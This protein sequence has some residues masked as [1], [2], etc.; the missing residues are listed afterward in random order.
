MNIAKDKFGAKFRFN[1]NVRKIRTTSDGQVEGVELASGEFLPADAV[2][3]NADL[4]YTYN[5]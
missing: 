2:V 4:V 3:S 5:K 1:A